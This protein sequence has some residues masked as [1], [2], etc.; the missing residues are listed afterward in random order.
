MAEAQ[1]SPHGEVVIPPEILQ[2]L[3]LQEG[4]RVEFVWYPDGRLGMVARG[5]VLPHLKGILPKPQ[6]DLT[7][8]EMCDLAAIR[9]ARDNA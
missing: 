7:V 4:G 5:P 6:C 1:V 3:G 9:A 8:E 2:A